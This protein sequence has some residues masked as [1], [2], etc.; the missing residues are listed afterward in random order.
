MCTGIEPWVIPTIVGAAG[1]AL[2]YASSNDAAEQQQKIINQAAAETEQLNKQKAAT[3]ENFA[4]KTFNP[5]DRQQNYE[6]AATK[7]EDSLVD[8][9]LK[10]NQG[11]GGGE[12]TDATQGA[13]SSDYTRGRAA[14]T[15]A[16]TDDILKRARLM[17]RAGA[18]SLLYNNEALEGGQLASDIAGINS[19]INRTNRSASTQLGAAGDKGSLVGGLLQGAAPMLGNVKLSLSGIAPP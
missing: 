11:N 14:A 2:N 5:Q 6:N 3:I 9:L 16:A 4:A 19:N 10:A 1:T 13:V 15:A 18:N 7:Q 8:A 17:A 12:V